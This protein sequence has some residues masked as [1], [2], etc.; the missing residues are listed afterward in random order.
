[1][2][3]L[4]VI[5]LVTIICAVCV[6]TPSSTKPVEEPN[7]E[8]VKIPHVLPKQSAIL[9]DGETHPEK[10]SDHLAYS[11]FFRLVAG[12]KT[13]AEKNRVKSYIRQALGHQDCTKPD[14]NNNSLNNQEADV[15]AIIAAAEEFNQR[16]APLDIQ[17]S[18]INKPYHE[19]E[20]MVP[21]SN[22]DKGRL[23]Q[24]QQ[25]RELMVADLAASLQHRL[26]ADGYKNL[27]KH[28][29]ERTKRKVKIFDAPHK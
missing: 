29:K 11:L 25:Q 14:K 23:K 9:V 7:R 2:K 10:I 8:P 18:D 6:T 27:R 20:H 16:I 13:E 15:N 4:S 5:F 12:R 19:T 24:L 17:V 22:S 1:M 21:M 26:S 3:L 28:I